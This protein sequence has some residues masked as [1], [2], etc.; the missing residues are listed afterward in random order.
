M[1]HSVLR[2]PVYCPSQVLLE[3]DTV[4]R[5]ITE[6]IVR[7]FLQFATIVT[8]FLTLPLFLVWSRRSSDTFLVLPFQRLLSKEAHAA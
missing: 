6:V 4:C 8:C 2:L 1:L 5:L 3:P 7:T